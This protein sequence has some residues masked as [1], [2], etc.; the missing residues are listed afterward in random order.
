MRGLKV[1][2]QLGG[3]SSANVGQ[4]P[5]ERKEAEGGTWHGITQNAKI[6]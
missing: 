2:G 3:A 4:K 6:D 1:K 5:P